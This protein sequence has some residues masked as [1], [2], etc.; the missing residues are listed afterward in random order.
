MA[1][2]VSEF[3]RQL[4]MLSRSFIPVSATDVLNHVENGASLPPYAVL[5]TFDDGFR[6]NL[7]Y[8]APILERLGIP[9][10]IHLTTG[11]I[12]QSGLLWTQELDERIL[13]WRHTALPM[14]RGQADAVLSDDTSERWQL[15]DR[16]RNV[17]KRLPHEERI[18]YLDRL[19]QKPLS[20]A[21]DWQQD[22]YS[23]LSWEEV[24]EL[25]SRGFSVGSHT[26]D[27]PILTTLS[28]SGLVSELGESKSRIE[29]ELGKPCLWLAYPNGGPADFSPEVVA[30]AEKAEYKIAFTLMERTNPQSLDPYK[31]DRICIPGEL[32]EDGFNARVNG[33]L[34]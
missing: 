1:T 5:V 22:L 32:S 27:H 13:S 26:V 33:F 18:A 21:E 28:P 9:A 2:R 11:H 8:A 25:D 20:A 24:R 10:L 7:T 34:T 6:N 12:G 23:F 15:A 3:S 19:R 16:V 31:I 14:P 4:E 17:C 30:A 29:S